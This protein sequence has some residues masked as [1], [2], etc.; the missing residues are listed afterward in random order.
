[1]KIVV[2]GAP[3]A[4]KGT[5]AK[6]VAIQFH[7]PHIST[8][9]I[10]RSYIQEG[11]EIGKKAKKYIE[12]GFLVPDKLMINLVIKRIHEKDCVEGYVLDGFP[13]TIAQAEAYE[14]VLSTNNEKLDC[15]INVAVPDED[16]VNRMAGRRA[17]LN[18]GA[19]YHLVFMP[20]QKEDTCDVCKGNLTLRE[21]D[22]PKTVLKRLCVYHQQTEP[23]IKFYKKREILY[24]VDGTEDIKD[25]F[26]RIVEIVE[27]K[28]G[29]NGCN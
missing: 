27:E 28:Y 12:K 26:V 21:D 22:E 5:Q 11:T 14:R 24:E 8:G 18:C 2:L 25:V 13:R 4:G 7:I 16:I 1:M 3:G 10:L 20:P 23:L 9:D 19:T 15:V 17:C 29:K 6:K